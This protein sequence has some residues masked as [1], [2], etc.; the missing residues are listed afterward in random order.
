MKKGLYRTLAWTGIR[1]NKK[2]YV[3]YLLTCAGMVMMCYIVSFLSSCPTFTLLRGGRDMRGIMGLGVGVLS[4]FS[5]SVLEEV[6]KFL[7]VLADNAICDLE[8]AEV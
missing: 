3:P 5:E 7:L 8:K 2:L 6:S 4:V 1:K